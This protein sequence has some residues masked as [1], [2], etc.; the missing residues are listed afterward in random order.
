MWCDG[1]TKMPDTD[2]KQLDQVVRSLAFSVSVATLTLVDFPLY[3]FYLFAPPRP[4]PTR[5]Q[6]FMELA[7]EALL[8]KML[9]S[10]ADQVQKKAFLK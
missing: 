9:A 5:T 8:P 1:M 2:A 3:H 4:T 7:R 10:Y 6:R